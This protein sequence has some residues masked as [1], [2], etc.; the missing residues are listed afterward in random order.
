MHRWVV[1]YIRERAHEARA[2]ADAQRRAVEFHRRG[3]LRLRCRS[4][5]QLRRSGRLDADHA[6]EATLS[7]ATRRY[8]PNVGEPALWVD[9]RRWGS[10]IG[11]IGGVVFIASY[12]SVLGTAVCT[13]A[14]VAGLM[15]TLAAL[16]A[17]YVWPVPLGP[18][19]ATSCRSAEVGEFTF[20]YRPF[21]LVAT[22]LYGEFQC[23]AR[24]LG[25]SQAGQQL[26]ANGRQQ[27]R[28]RQRP[29]GHQLVHDR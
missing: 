23:G 15:L 17:H 10:L 25:A 18:Q 21:A 2:R 1:Q 12:S 27:V 19:R 20:Q 29:G 9:P 5:R 13:V 26:S 14:W 28:V 24:L 11:L 6:A 3:P 22:Q 16:S 4:A 7:A 8:G